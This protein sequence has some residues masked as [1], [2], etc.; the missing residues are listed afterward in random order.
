MT[1]SRPEEPVYAGS[2]GKTQSR[3]AIYNCRCGSRFAMEVFTSIDVSE[4]ADLVQML[5]AGGL[6][7]G[8]CGSCATPIAV[9]TRCVLHDPVAR[10]LI[11]YL[12]ERE[13]HAEIEARA[14]LL[15][16]LAKDPSSG[17]PSYAIN[18]EVAFGAEGL[19][20]ALTRRPARDVENRAREIEEAE[21][22]LADR[23]QEMARREA[24]LAER[25]AEAE[26]K[27]QE[28]DAR[29]HALDRHD[30]LPAI[31][32]RPEGDLRLSFL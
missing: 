4:R 20:A 21:R 23:E 12:P 13:R 31:V 1:P 32:G 29:L 8:Q 5:L 7:R 26:R 14:N 3:F 17:L 28:V 10:R 2:V 27:F 18:F 6:N 25:V 9:D 22:R 24:A 16:D 19:H 15:M 11:L 30:D